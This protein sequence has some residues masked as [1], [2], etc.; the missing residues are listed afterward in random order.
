[1]NM[2]QAVITLVIGMALGAAAA[3]YL[4]RILQ[5][6]LP[7]A[8]AGKKTVVTGTVMAKEKNAASL[9]LTLN[10][11]QGALLATFTRKADETN[12]LVSA[13]DSVELRIKSYQP[14]IEDPTVLRVVKSA[15]AVPGESASAAAPPSTAQT[16]TVPARPAAAGKPAAAS[17]ASK[18]SRH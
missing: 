1:M 16:G 12:L 3:V 9:L 2:R 5:P 7:D 18:G 6:Y 8:L 10:T 13:G 14:F 11:A 15:T 17:Q 4:P